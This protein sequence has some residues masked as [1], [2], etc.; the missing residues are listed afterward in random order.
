MN[1]KEEKKKHLPQ[2]EE[3]KGEESYRDTHSE[4]MGRG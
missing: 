4:D 2:K 1:Q 3:N